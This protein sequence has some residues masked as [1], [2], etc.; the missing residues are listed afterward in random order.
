MS[1]LPLEVTRSGYDLL[2]DPILNKGIAFS[3]AERD[4][5]GLHGLLPPHLG[6][7]EEQVSRR[8]AMLRSLS[9]DLERYDALRD[10]QDNNET[11]FYGLLTRH[12]TE[13][14]PLVYTPTVGRGCQY[15]SQIYRKPRG[16]FLSLPNQGRLAAILA[17]RTFDKV[18]AIVVTDGERILGLGDLGVGG[19]GIPVGKLSLY[20]ACGGLHPSTT[21]PIILDVGTDNEEC[22]NDPSYLGWRHERVRGE[23]YDAFIEAFVTAVMARWPHVLLQWEDFAL[24]NATRLLERYRK[25]LCTFNDDIQGTAAVALGTLLSAVEVTGVPLAAQRIAILGAGSAGCGIASLLI[26]AMVSAGM[27]PAAARS[28]LFMV[29]ANGLLVEGQKLLPFQEDLAQPAEAI[30]GWSLE[31]AN[32][33]GLLDVVVN[34]Q[35]TVLVGVTGHPGLFTEAVVRAMART[36]VRP[37]ILPLSNPTTR[38]EA[39]PADLLAWTEGRAI[40]GT[41]SPFPPVEVGPR[42]IPVAQTNNAYVFP[43]VG[44]GAIAVQASEITDTMFLAAAKALADASPARLNPAD[45]LLPPVES[46][47]NV[48]LRVA[49]A[50]ARQARREGVAGNREDDIEALVHARMWEPAYRDYVRAAPNR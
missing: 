29:D 30:A 4:G 10:M 20:S 3:E 14:L 17:D 15:F 19:M 46:L 11:A 22:L 13:A 25:R 41:G 27:E 5:F 31:T 23:Q 26:K 2:N 43:G 47:R 36:S 35:P 44:L 16:L 28:R 45:P 18:S 50:V 6:T 24:E 39:T 7:L 12:L 38:S 49:L 33:V 48:A 9:N 42:K 32:R 21:L 37:V 1:E 8:L 34:A 40:I